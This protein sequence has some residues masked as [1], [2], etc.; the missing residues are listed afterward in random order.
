[1]DSLS[2][3]ALGAAIGE[4]TLGARLGR[5]AILIGGLLGTLPDLD[6]LVQYADAVESYTYHRS[7]SHSLLV[8]SLASPIIAWLLY[9]LIPA[10]WA[11]N[12][13]R[14]SICYINCYIN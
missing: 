7:W 12:S 13:S 6:V 9:K 3:F 5:K 11:V 8:L 10:R 1:M 4:A 14:L 2:Q